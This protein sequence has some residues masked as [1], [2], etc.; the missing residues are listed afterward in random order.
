MIKSEFS[1]YRRGDKDVRHFILLKWIFACFA[2]AMAGFGVSYYFCLNVIGLPLTVISI[3]AVNIL[4]VIGFI[5]FF[6]KEPDQEEKYKRAK[7]PWE[8]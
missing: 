1:K 8:T 3:I 6:S 7:Q 4:V 5:N 2:L